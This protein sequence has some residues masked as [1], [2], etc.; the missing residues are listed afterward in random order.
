MVL[1]RRGGRGRLR[2]WGRFA[3][4]DSGVIYH[5]FRPN[6]EIPNQSAWWVLIEVPLC[7]ICIGY[8]WESSDLSREAEKWPN[9]EIGSNIMHEWGGD[10]RG[11]DIFHC[12]N[13]QMTQQKATI[14]RGM[15]L[16]WF[17]SDGM[18]RI[19]MTGVVPPHWVR[20]CIY[21]EGGGLCLDVDCC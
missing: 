17:R 12:S 19:L 6:L 18:A 1:W 11:G 3:V 20:A 15:I 5:V 13:R 16:E 4:A 14:W 8:N 2:D 10:G 7:F 9:C 21:Y